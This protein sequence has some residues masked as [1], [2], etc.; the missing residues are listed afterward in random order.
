MHEP[1]FSQLGFPEAVFRRC[2]SQ[3]VFLKILQIHRKT[4]VL[5]SLF[6]K[7]KGLK[8]CNFIKKR[9]QHRS[10]PEKFTKLSRTLSFTEQTKKDLLV[11]RKL[12]P[13]GTMEGC[14][15]LTLPN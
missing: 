7:F 5:E 9:L 15:I 14:Y 10:V 6:N 3:Q 4:L 13:K 11:T 2:S 1:K 12:I 8:A